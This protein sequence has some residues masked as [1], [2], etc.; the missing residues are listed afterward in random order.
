MLP[1]YEIQ[2][3]VIKLQTLRDQTVA[4]SQFPTSAPVQSSTLAPTTLNDYQQINKMINNWQSIL[5]TYQAQNSKL[6]DMF[7]NEMTQYNA[8]VNQ[9][10]AFQKIQDIGSIT[11]TASQSIA[12]GAEAIKSALKAL[13]YKEF[14]EVTNPMFLLKGITLVA[15]VLI[16]SGIQ[17]QLLNY[18]GNMNIRNQFQFKDY[19]NNICQDFS[20]DN[21]N[22]FSNFFSNACSMPTTLST[23]DSSADSVYFYNQ[24]CKT[25]ALPSSSDYPGGL[26][27]G[28]G[29]DQ[30]LFQFLQSQK[31]YLTYGAGAPISF[32]WTS[33]ITDSQ[34]HKTSFTNEFETSSANEGATKAALV[35]YAETSKIKVELKENYKINVGQS[36]SSEHEN[37][38]TVNVELGDEQMGM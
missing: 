3:L 17:G 5:S 36:A 11:G 9:W 12:L 20:S 6:T 8:I 25:Q 18:C 2:Q 21:W 35:P 14:T 27:A 26:E 4:L 13:K 33:K 15:Q 23:S 28:V 24:V 38:R 29:K 10:V 19:T 1:V 37:V 16:F 30:S 31:K 34:D 7:T 22:Q 32:A